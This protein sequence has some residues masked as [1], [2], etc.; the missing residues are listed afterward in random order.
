[1]DCIKEYLVEFKICKIETHTD[2]LKPK[3]GKKGEKREH[4]KTT[5]SKIDNLNPNISL[6]TPIKT[7]KMDKKQNHMM[8]T[9]DIP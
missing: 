5:E 4:G 1:M 6:I 2:T 9:K 3:E 8:L 7:V